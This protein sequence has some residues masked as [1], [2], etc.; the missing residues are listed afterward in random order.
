MRKKKQNL[1]K[2]LSIEKVNDFWNAHE[3]AFFDQKVIALVICK[4]KASLEQDRWKGTG[5]PFRKTLGKILYKKRDV[6]LW[7]DAFKIVTSTSVYD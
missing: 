2:S 3:E 1:S 6:V 7:L 4:S 5:I